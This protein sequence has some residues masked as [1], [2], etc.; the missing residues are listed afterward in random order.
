M[1]F[2]KTKAYGRRTRSVNET[3]G[4]CCRAGASEASV[5]A[6]LCRLNQSQDVALVEVG[7]ER[8]HDLVAAP[9]NHVEAA[10]PR[11]EDL[12]VGDLPRAL[13]QVLFGIVGDDQGDPARAA[14]HGISHHGSLPRVDA[15]EPHA[16]QLR[17]LRE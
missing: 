15:A 14:D 4:D 12:A 13:A 7:D 1:G 17:T 2:K 5:S 3:A 8:V 16:L 10:G 9:G 6:L 11:D